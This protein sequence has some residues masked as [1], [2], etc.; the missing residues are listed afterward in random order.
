MSER[1]KVRRLT[2]WQ[3]RV[4]VSYSQVGGAPWGSIGLEGFHAVLNAPRSA[5]PKQNGMLKVATF[6]PPKPGKKFSTISG[7]YFLVARREGENDRGGVGNVVQSSR[8]DVYV[9]TGFHAIK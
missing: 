4:G 1:D 2:I 9:Q 8:G 5:L 3:Q 7:V 6:N